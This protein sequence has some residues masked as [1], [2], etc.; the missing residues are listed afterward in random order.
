MK[1]CVRVHQGQEVYKRDIL[2][3][4][5]Q[6]HYLR[7]ETVGQD[8]FSTRW[9]TGVSSGQLDATWQ[10]LIGTTHGMVKVRTIKRHATHVEKWIVS[11][12]FKIQ[13]ATWEPI[14][15]V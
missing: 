12:F 7:P 15:A 6:I 1:N 14:L 9:E 8:E 5:E 11:N 4:G 3:F 2:E 10:I 13:G